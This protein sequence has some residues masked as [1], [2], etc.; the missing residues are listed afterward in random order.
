[1]TLTA[2]PP[3]EA[4]AIIAYDSDGKAQLFSTLPDTHDKLRE[5]AI[6]TTGGHCGTPKPEGHGSLFG[7]VTFAYVDAFGRLSA[8]SAAITVK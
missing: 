7:K 2:A 1:L 3:A 5:L 4:V 6:D 8:K